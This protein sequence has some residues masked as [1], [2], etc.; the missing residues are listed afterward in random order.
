MQLFQD[1]LRDIEDL[2][3]R[4]ANLVRY[5][6]VVSVNP[7]AGT[8]RVNFGGDTE[9]ADLP[10]SSA[11]AGGARVWS[12]VVVG[13]Q[14][15]V[16]CPSG[17]TAQGIIAGSVPCEA[18]PAPSGDGATYQINL[19]GGVVISVSGG[20]VHI[21]APGKVIIAGDVEVSGDV[22]ASGISLVHHKHGGI[23]PGTSKTAE[24]E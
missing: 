15:M 3:R 8:A 11:R 23:T 10:I 12:P 24:P 22:V 21:T 6:T 1:V 13:E 4:T 7:G 2:H 14:V 9:S 5:G 17:D 18:F 20:A 16:L 19:P